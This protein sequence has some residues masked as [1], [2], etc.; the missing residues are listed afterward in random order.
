M[1]PGMNKATPF[2]FSRLYGRRKGRPLSEYKADLMQKLLPRVRVVLGE[3]NV[4]DLKTLFQKVPSAL[5]L[6]IGFGGGE[7]LAAQAGRNSGIGYIGCEPFVNGV[8]GLLALIDRQKLANV[9]IFPEDARVL[10]DALPA[11]C[12][13]GCFVLYPDPW[14]KKRHAER[15]FINAENLDRLARTM[16]PG[17]ELRLATDVA[18][19]AAWMREQVAGPP[20][21][22]LEVDS[23]TPPQDW[24]ATRYENKGVKAGRVPRYFV[25]RKVK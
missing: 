3:K 18:L 21:F 20:A 13:D 25:T 6:E 10:L 8:A 12:L 23:A 9:R 4:V 16:K 2:P 14:P 11:A 5:W 22:V 17:A 24:V 1:T 15:R 19:L 7:H